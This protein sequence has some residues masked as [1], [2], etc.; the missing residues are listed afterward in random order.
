MHLQLP[1]HFSP[2]AE[3]HR[4]RLYR[5]GVIAPDLR[6][7]AQILT[8]LREGV[9][10]RRR[11]QW[12]TC[13]LILLLRRHQSSLLALRGALGGVAVGVGPLRQ[14]GLQH[15]SLA[16]RGPRRRAL[17][18]LLHLVVDFSFTLG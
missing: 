1:R 11:H 8:G 5:R 9:M 2:P 18:S 14:I 10:R 13:R 17:G 16:G 3:V 12:R 15:F 4:R 7:R 6:I